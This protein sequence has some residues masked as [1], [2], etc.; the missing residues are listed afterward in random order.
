MKVIVLTVSIL[1]LNG[2]DLGTETTVKD[3]TQYVL[4]SNGVEYALLIS[5][6]TFN[7]GDS[8]IVNY[9]V[10]NL[11]TTRR[12]FYFSNLQQFGY[13]IKDA[14][15]NQIDYYPQVFLPVTSSLTLKYS[16]SKSYRTTVY[17]DDRNNIHWLKGEYHITAFLLDLQSPDISLTF[18]I[19]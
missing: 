7:Y 3:P 6:T 18:Q 2:C 13:N 4:V 9:R 16:Q 11:N 17:F 14:Y 8:L 15:G 5:G 1:I 19:Q 10:R 12:I